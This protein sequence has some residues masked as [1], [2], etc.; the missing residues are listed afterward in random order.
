M[1]IELM[2]NFKAP[3]RAVSISDFWSRWHM[4]LSTWFKDYLYIPLGGNRVGFYRL[5]F[6]LFL[7]FVVSGFWHGAS[8]TFIIWGA[9]HGL[10]TVIE[11]L[12]NKYFKFN[13][14][15]GNPNFLKLMLKRGFVFYLVSF[16]WIF[17]RAENFSQAMYIAKNYVLGIPSYIYNLT[18]N[19][20]LWLEPLIF[21]KNLKEYYA[22]FFLLGLAMMLLFY[23][24]KVDY[25]TKFINY[26]DEKK[27]I[28]RTIFYQLLLL[29]IL[30]IGAFHSEQEFIYFQF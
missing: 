5:C 8:W 27:F 9:L 30:F 17:F 14:S 11:M 3:Y 26:L 18:Q 22:E 19:G 29:F 28:Y 20:Y 15:N 4:S 2:Q 6:N 24:N 10:F 21:N 1:G 12:M 13:K 7:V 16:A 25:K 23:I